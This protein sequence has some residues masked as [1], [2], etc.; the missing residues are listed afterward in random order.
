VMRAL[1]PGGGGA[2]DGAGI[3]QALLGTE[4]H[5]DGAVL[6]L[7]VDLLGAL[8]VR[9]NGKLMLIQCCYSFNHSR[10]AT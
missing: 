7:Q 1:F 8:R 10:K 6:T 5:L 4:V 3:L 9:D 2:L